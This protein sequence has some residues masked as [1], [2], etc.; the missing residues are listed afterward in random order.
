MRFLELPAPE[1]R[2][3]VKP[4]LRLLVVIANPSDTPTLDVEQEWVRLSAA[5]EMLE[6]RGL[7]QV[8]RLDQATLMALQPVSYT[9]LRA[10]E[11]VLDLVCRLLLAKKKKQASTT[12]SLIDR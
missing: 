12:V 2:A 3:R 6:A 8:E 7:L 11:T 5:V 10:H 9:H 1:S 4:P